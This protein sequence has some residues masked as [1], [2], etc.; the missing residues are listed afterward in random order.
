MTALGRDPSVEKLS[1]SNRVCSDH[2]HE[3][4]KIYTNNTVRL[5]PNAV[6]SLKLKKQGGLIQNERYMNR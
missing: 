6:P 5:K 1:P 3:A 2:F 4:D